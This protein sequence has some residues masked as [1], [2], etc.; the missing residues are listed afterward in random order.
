MCACGPLRRC[1]NPRSIWLFLGLVANRQPYSACVEIPLV[2]EIQ[3]R[4]ISP[5]EWIKANE[6][7]LRETDEWRRGKPGL[8]LPKGSVLLVGDGSEM[9]TS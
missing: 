9:E 8:D 1:W 2:N 4:L 6:F 7:V 3:S 5:E